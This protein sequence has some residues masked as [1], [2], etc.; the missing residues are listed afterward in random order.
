VQDIL[1]EFVDKT[2]GLSEQEARFR[3]QRIGINDELFS[4]LRRYGPELTKS[5]DQTLLVSDRQQQKTRDTARALTQ[6]GFSSRLAFEALASELA[7]AVTFVAEVLSKLTNAFT[8]FLNIFAS[9]P[10][11]FQGG[12]KVGEDLRNFFKN[13]LPDDGG[14][15][16]LN[17][18]F[19]SPTVLPPSVQIMSS[20]PNVTQ[21]VDITV[22]GAQSPVQTGNTIKR[23]LDRG[24]SD[25]YNQSPA[26]PGVNY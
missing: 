7:P 12:Q 17:K 21:N 5:L 3:A 9:V 22:D 10:D 15:A 19:L 20:R 13:L 24:I 14:K 25:A 2:K 4:A 16:A 18:I 8:R 6:L 26:Y 1:R 11:P 23:S